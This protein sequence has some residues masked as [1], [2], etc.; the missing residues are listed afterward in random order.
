MTDKVFDNN[1]VSIAGEVIS[2]FTF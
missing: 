1:Q 2:D